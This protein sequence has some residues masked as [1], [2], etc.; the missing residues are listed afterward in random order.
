M[1]RFMDPMSSM[2]AP[3]ET[4]QAQLKWFNPNKGF[5]FVTYNNDAEAFLHAS[6]LHRAAAPP[7]YPGAELVCEIGSGPK[8]AQVNRIE[9]IISHGDPDAIQRDDS[10]GGDRPPRGD[11]GDRPPR[12]FD[13]RGPRGGGDRFGS[14]DRSGGDRFGGDRPQR[15]FDDRGPRSGGN[16][17]DSGPPEPFHPEPGDQEIMGT[18]KWFK[19]E[20]GFGFA[21]AD[22]SENDIFIHKT[23]MRRS[24]LDNLE[25]GSRIKMTVRH[26]QKG[27]EAVY[28]QADQ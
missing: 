24:G 12:N 8:G 7:L 5:G 3:G 21:N 28:I 13:D 11:F 14:N 2:G 27:Q 22:G 17:F 23:A 4:F 20:K 1:S 15:N 19:P 26:V 18:L 6:V 9:Q 25:P 16:R 10:R